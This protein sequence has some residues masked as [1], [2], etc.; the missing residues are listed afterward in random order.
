MFDLIGVWLDT[1][2]RPYSKSLLMPALA[3]HVIIINHRSGLPLLL[4]A[5]LFFAW[6]GDVFLLSDHYFLFG[7]G[8]FLVMQIIYAAEFMKNWKP[9]MPSAIIAGFLLFG[10]AV[11]MIIFLS[12]SISELFIPVVIYVIAI[13]TMV[14]VAQARDRSLPGY[15][16]VLVGSLF[17]L[18]SD[19]ALAVGLF[20]DIDEGVLTVMLTYGIAQLLITEGI[21]SKISFSHS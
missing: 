15:S 10:S 4:L 3:V 16:M 7:L 20:T 11:A 2:W 19:A 13:A 14:F 17:F 6:L 21:L 5:G 12:A 1:P 9:H 8:S 18:I